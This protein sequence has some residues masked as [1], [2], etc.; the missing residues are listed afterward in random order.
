MDTSKVKKIKKSKKRSKAVVPELADDK[1]E[2]DSKTGTAKKRKLIAIVIVVLLGCFLFFR[3]SSTSE[4]ESAV[5]KV[6]KSVK[7]GDKGDKGDSDEESVHL[8]GVKV[9][10]SKHGNLGW[11]VQ[12]GPLVTKRPPRECLVRRISPQVTTPFFLV[13]K[14]AKW[15]RRIYTCLRFNKQACASA[16]MADFE[17]RRWKLKPTTKPLNERVLST[18]VISDGVTLGKLSQS[19][20]EVFNEIYTVNEGSTY[21]NVILGADALDGTLMEQ[22]QRRSKFAKSYGCAYNQLKIQP[23]QYR[24]DVTGECEKMQSTAKN[25]GSSPWSLH[26]F[27]S[28]GEATTKS[29][30]PGEISAGAFC[31]THAKLS[32][33]SES[34][35]IGSMVVESPLKIE[36]KLFDVRSYLLI[37]STMPMM[38]FFRR[39]YVRR[40]NSGT[41]LNSPYMFDDA[42]ADVISLEMFQEHLAK[43]KVTG[44]HYV[45]TFLQSSMKQIAL[46]VFHAARKQ[47]KRRKGTFQI[48]AV[49][50]VIDKEFRVHLE[51]T[52]GNP[53]MERE[54]GFDF[55]GLIADMHDLVQELHEYPAAF[56]G[57]VK[58]DK[59][60]S[61]EL[62]FSELSETCHKI[63]YNPCH[64][65]IDYNDR[66]LTK[67]NKHVGKVQATAKRLDNEDKRIVKKT[68]E[69]KKS[70]CKEKH[71]P[72][73]GPKCN[74][75]IESM[76]QELFN[77]LFNEH[78]ASFNPNEFRLPRPGEVFPH[79]IV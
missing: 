72:Y 55:S 13:N 58:G 4:T 17:S 6:S 44:S 1:Y 14:K 68:E 45:D 30:T 46:F 15:K 31:K 75:L 33:A 76:D 8:D 5:I 67:Q 42:S 79:E 22:F 56:E 23:P 36:G 52:V 10:E 70:I 7:A 69:K 64:H 20:P 66:D 40:L 18:F 29:T 43:G 9:I 60:G 16:V 38:V 35:N 34:K 26:A 62:I 12:Q 41:K 39:G 49:D 65:F 63:Q 2:K 73:P 78:E 27:S 48:F 59:Y 74:K 11:S 28:T 51:K 54:S 3:D 47:L 57:M 19:K 32:H 25:H 53:V 37:G 71:L 50:Y 21:L 24:F 61:W 77:K